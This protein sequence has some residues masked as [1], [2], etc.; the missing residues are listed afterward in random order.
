MGLSASS[1]MPLLSR[2]EEYLNAHP[3]GDING[4]ARW[5]L[6]IGPRQKA[7]T[8]PIEPSKESTLDPSAQSALLISRM[9]RILQLRTKPVV[10]ELGFTKP[11]EFSMLVQ[12]A[13]MNRPNKKQVCQELL[14]EGSTGVEIT[15]R[16]AI[17]GFISEQPDAN[18][19]RSALLSLSEKGREVLIKGYAKLSAVHSDFLEGLRDEEKQHLVSLLRRLNEFH[20]SQLPP[21]S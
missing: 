16:L 19:R 13:I 11:E 18:D 10:K 3:D 8:E 2:W 21:T 4:F 12:T 17:K 7:S 1:I 6:D 20:S 14:I 15:K 5:I 9:A